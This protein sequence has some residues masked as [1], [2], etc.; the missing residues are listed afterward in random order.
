M[1]RIGQTVGRMHAAGIVHGD[2]T[3]SNIML[4]GGEQP[5]QQH[6]QQ[7]D[8]HLEQTTSSSSTAAFQASSAS[9]ASS[10]SIVLIDFGLASQT[11]QEEDRAVD[12]YVLER[13]FGATHPHAETLFGVVLEAYGR[14]YKG[15]PV[16]L[17]R[18]ADVRA[19]GRKKSMVG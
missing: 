10:S 5:G 8:Q 17:R 19:R 14:E 18:L 12:L 2:L 11:T 6:D 3:T 16:V 9:S 1:H 15:G 7:R 13:A 4:R